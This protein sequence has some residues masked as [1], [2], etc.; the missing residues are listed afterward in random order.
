MK[1]ILVW[2]TSPSVAG[3]QKM[4]LTVMG[5]LKNECEFHCLIPG[6]GALSQSLAALGIPYTV[7]GDQTLPA[8]V[9]GMGA[10]F[11]YAWLSLKNIRAS[12]KA[13]RRFRPD[14]LYAPG[15]AALPWSAV[16]GRLSGK[17]VVWH[18]HHLFADGPTKKLLN[19]TAKWGCVRRIAAV[20]QAVG[21]QITDSQ[22]RQKVVC[23]YNPIDI[24]R[25][26]GGDGQAVRAEIEAALGSKPQLILSEIAI[27]REAKLQNVFV[28]VIAALRKMDVPVTGV[29]VGDALTDDDKEFKTALQ[30][31]IQRLGLTAHIYFAG[32]RE[33]V[34]DYLAATD[35]V[36]VPS[37]VEGLS[38]AAMEAMCAKRAVITP[39]QG[40]AAELLRI[41][42]SGYHYPTSA[43]PEEIAQIIA[44]ALRAPCAEKAENGYRFCQ[45][46]SMDAY[47][48]S[49]REYFTV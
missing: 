37:P 25:Y 38:L 19:L 1:K 2:E 8:G 40:G 16:C 21:A 34:K 12:M 22:G 3:G 39:D 27:L 33:N 28:D 5:L 7:M 45:E 17:P 35:A 42:D 9:K 15:P 47:L 14:I 36:L 4:T 10:Y 18:L 13:I 44:T 49:L 20:S 46:H 48:E 30:A 23:L 24:R 43:T 29:L 6:E 26:E 31:Q 32:H 11:R 41:S